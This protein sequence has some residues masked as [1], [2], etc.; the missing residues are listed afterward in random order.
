MEQPNN[1]LTKQR[2]S[3]MVEE[4]VRDGGM[5]YM[6]AILHICD[7]RDIDPL[8]I[9]RIVSPSIRSKL[10]V[11]AQSKNLLPRSSSSGSLDDFL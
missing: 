9:G 11:E 1:I 10:E 8:D 3:L 6:E 5:S 4:L 7:E 2:F